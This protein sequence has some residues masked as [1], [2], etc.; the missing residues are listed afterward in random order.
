MRPSVILV[1]VPAHERRE[2][3]ARQ[4]VALCAAYGVLLEVTEDRT[5]AH[6]VLDES[7]VSCGP[8]HAFSLLEPVALSVQ[9]LLRGLNSLS[10]LEALYAPYPPP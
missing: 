8:V 6:L 7:G 3:A 4:A 10:C 9:T 1:H 5:R 2:R